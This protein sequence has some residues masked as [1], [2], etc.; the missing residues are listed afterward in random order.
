MQADRSKCPCPESAPSRPAGVAA[1]MKA[2]EL[3]DLIVATLARQHGGPARRWRLALGQV[4]VYD[5][6]THPDINWTVDPYGSAAE[7]AVVERLLDDLRP[8]Y[9]YVERD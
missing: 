8:A 2:G 1:G 4:R 5:R 7:N 6:S 3:R 9:P